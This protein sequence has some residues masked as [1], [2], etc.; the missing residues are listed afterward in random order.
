MAG[1]GAQHLL[2]RPE[3]VAPAARPDHGQE[4]EPHARGRQR[5]RVRQ[6]RRREP[7]DPLL[8]RAQCSE[9][10]NDELQL[11][12]PLARRKDFGQRSGRPA[13]AGQLAVKCR[14]AARHRG[15]RRTGGRATAPHRLA[16]EDFLQGGH[17]T[18]FIYST[19]AA[20]KRAGQ[21]C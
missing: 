15:R 9:R 3:R 4:F 13:A 7:R 16:I 21:P 18:V 8:L 19:A 10:G 14:E 12:Q 2:G 17:G 6:V 20:C 5:R 1:A 11:A